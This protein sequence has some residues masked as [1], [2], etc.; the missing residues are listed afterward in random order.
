[1]SDDDSFRQRRMLIQAI[2]AAPFVACTE[3]QGSPAPAG[4]NDEHEFLLQ[5]AVA[6]SCMPRERSGRNATRE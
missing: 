1:M 4:P 3:S 2:S 5:L 6:L